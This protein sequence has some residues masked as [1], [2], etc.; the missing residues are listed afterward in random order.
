MIFSDRNIRT[1]PVS[2]TDYCLHRGIG[3]NTNPDPTSEKNGK[4]IDKKRKSTLM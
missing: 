3:W 1:E 2:S 4:R